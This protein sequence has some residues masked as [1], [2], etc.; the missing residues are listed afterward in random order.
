MLLTDTVVD[1]VDLE[2]GTG[3]SVKPEGAC[4]GEHCVPL[5]SSAR[6]EDGR[7]DVT[8]LADRLGMPLVEEPAFGLWALGPESAVTGRALSTAQAPEL[9]L[10][11]FDGGTFALSSLRGTR[12][13]LVAWA[14]WCGCANDLPVWSALRDR[15]RTSGIEVVTVAMDVTG[16]DVARP[17]VD[18]A[19]GRAHPALLDR[20]TSWASCSGWSTCR[21]SCGSTSTA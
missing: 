10:P 17:F 1:A 19:T 11:S 12:V 20:S 3:W 6:L 16:F 18:A 14:S 15:I 13:V 8:V 2:R 4:K 9:E 21:T 5:P 7:V